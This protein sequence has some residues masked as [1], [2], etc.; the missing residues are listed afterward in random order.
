MANPITINKT[1][2]CE[3]RRAGIAISNIA[4]KVNSGKDANID[5]QGYRPHSAVA[6]F[7]SLGEVAPVPVQAFA[8]VFSVQSVDRLLPGDGVPGVAA[9]VLHA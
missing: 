7:F 6:T 4:G 2:Q 9:P 5:L 8:R 1:V 3:R